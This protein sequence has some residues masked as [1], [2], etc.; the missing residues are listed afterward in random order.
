MKKMWIPQAIIIPML[1]LA[2]NPDNPYGYYILLRW[3]CCAAFVFLALYA[4]TLEKFGWVWVFGVT[5]AIYN[6]ILIVPGTREMWSVVNIV[7]IGIAIVS[8]IVLK[9]R[10][11]DQ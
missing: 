6:P 3:V 7:T 2:L 1:I 10:S 4:I 11:E 8:I 5:A 9:K